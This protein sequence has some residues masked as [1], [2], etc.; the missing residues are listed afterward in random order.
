MD[1][2]DRLETAASRLADRNIW[3]NSNRIGLLR[4]HAAVSILGGAQILLY[5]GPANIEGSVGVWTRAAL[6]F[7]AI[8]GGIVLSYGLAQRPRHIRLEAVGLSVIGLWDFTMACGMAYSR[9]AQGTYSPVPL[10]H[11]LPAEYV[12]PYPVTVYLGLFA[13]ICIHLW[14]LRRMAKAGGAA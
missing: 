6:G 3:E 12:R 2:L 13:L 14:T 9:I 8:I 1:P 10:T 4:V 7:L 11:L 5:G